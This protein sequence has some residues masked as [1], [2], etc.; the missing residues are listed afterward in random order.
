MNFEH[1]DYGE[2][3]R[4]SF[5]QVP[6]LLLEEPEFKTLSGDAKLLYSLMLE[7]GYLSRINGWYEK[8]VTEMKEQIAAEEAAK[9][10][11]EAAEKA[12]E[13]E[14]AQTPT[15]EVEPEGIRPERRAEG[16]G[17]GLQDQ[18]PAEKGSRIQRVG[19]GKA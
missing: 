13:E 4:Y 11:E 14:A 6:K 10:A 7:R 17:R 3:R 8:E 5:L 15:P 1:F 16:N 2:E 18:I 9:E 19:Q 12:K